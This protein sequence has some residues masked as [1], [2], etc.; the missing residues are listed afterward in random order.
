MKIQSPGKVPTRRETRAAAEKKASKLSRRQHARRFTAYSGLDALQRK[1]ECRLEKLECT[2]AGDSLE[3]DGDDDNDGESDE[4]QV[5]SDVDGSSEDDLEDSGEEFKAGTKRKKSK[6][7]APVRGGKKP[8]RNKSKSVSLA[9]G[10]VRGKAGPSKPSQQGKKKTKK[11]KV[12]SFANILLDENARKLGQV[13]SV[14]ELNEPDYFNVIT[15]PSRYPRRH[16]C[17]ITGQLAP[18][19][20]SESGLRFASNRAYRQLN[21]QPPS[22]LRSSGNAP[23]FESLRIVATERENAATKLCRRS[24][25]GLPMDTGDDFNQTTET[26]NRG[27]D[28]TKSI[29]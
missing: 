3:N 11:R 13:K 7:K 23:Y 19:K 29:S 15:K 27:S 26:E 18:Y 6:G 2:N 4:Y 14:E 20:D 17:V 1:V 10:R 16:I 12:R 8:G 22:W 25:D 21:E 24:T 9:K 5:E 28:E